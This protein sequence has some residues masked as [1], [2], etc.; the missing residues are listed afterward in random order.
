MTT[1][2]M[3]QTDTMRGVGG[4]LFAGTLMIIGGFF[5][6]LEGL[7]GIFNGNFFRPVADYYDISGTTWGWVHLSLGILVLLAGF[8]VMV[9]QT[10]ARVTGIILVSISAI[11]NFMF[12]PWAPFWAITIIA[13]DIWI[14]HALAVYRPLSRV[15][16]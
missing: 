1:T 7:A 5:W 8:A 4:A 12:I 3:T 2:Q 14:I 11:V 15:T 6:A 9:G 10:W 16:D 13:I